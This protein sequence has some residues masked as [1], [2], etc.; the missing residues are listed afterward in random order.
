M[1]YSVTSFSKRLSRARCRTR[2]TAIALWHSWRVYPVGGF[3]RLAAIYLKQLLSMHL[4]RKQLASREN[5]SLW[6]S[7]LRWCMKCPFFDSRLL[8]C[9]TP[10]ETMDL[11]ETNQ[12]SR[13]EPVGCWCWMPLAAKDPKK[14]CWAALN[15]IG[16]WPAE[17]TR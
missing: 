1:K 6:R 13:R 3:V 8:T 2:A 9:G 5:Q 16:G 15:N 7:R 14:E 11:V 12:Q 4:R 10:G 17:L